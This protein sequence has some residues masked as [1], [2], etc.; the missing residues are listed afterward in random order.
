MKFNL[1]WV[2]KQYYFPQKIMLTG[3]KTATDPNGF[4]HGDLYILK[5]EGANYV[6]QVGKVLRRMQ[7]GL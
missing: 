5:V 7:P 1:W 3:N 6:G 4:S 2:Q